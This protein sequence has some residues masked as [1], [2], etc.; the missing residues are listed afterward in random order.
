MNSFVGS[1]MVDICLRNL[2]LL[3]NQRFLVLVGVG[4]LIPR[5][6][7]LH[8]GVEAGGSGSR[9]LGWIV[10]ALEESSPPTPS[11]SFI[12]SCNCIFMV[13]CYLFPNEVI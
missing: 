3:T 7:H 2:H 11:V 9:I 8:K 6:C 1:V 5:L 12:S 13:L 4:V 10:L